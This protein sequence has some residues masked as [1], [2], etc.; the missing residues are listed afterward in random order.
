MS[1][2]NK[3]K[4]QQNEVKDYW[5]E[6]EAERKVKDARAKEVSTRPHQRPVG[7]GRARQKGHATMNCNLS[8]SLAKN[9]MYLDRKPRQP[10]TIGS[11]QSQSHNPGEE[12]NAI[13]DGVI[14]R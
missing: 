6:M 5:R 11:L 9:W 1:N 3:N 7:D 13:I 4:S 10:E 8:A 2:K 14:T 12:E